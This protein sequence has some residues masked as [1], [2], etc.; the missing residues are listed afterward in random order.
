MP[1]R[2]VNELKLPYRFIDDDPDDFDPPGDNV[3]VVEFKPSIDAL[4]TLAETHPESEKVSRATTWGLQAFVWLNMLVVPAILFYGDMPRP[5]IAVFI[6]NAAITI[7]VLPLL[8]KSDLK[9]YYARHFPEFESEHLR[10]ELHRSGVVYRYQE[11]TAFYSWENFIQLTETES[12]LLFYMKAGNGFAVSKSGFEYDHEIEEFLS[13]TQNYVPVVR[14][15]R[16]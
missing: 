13:F 6:F 12:S 10:V 15:N 3:L 8:R 11:D 2:S 14:S 1:Y 4:A 16:G 5:A 9:R 7:F